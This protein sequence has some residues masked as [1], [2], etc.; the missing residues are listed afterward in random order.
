MAESLKKF[1]LP[2]D[3]DDNDNDDL[4]TEDDDDEDDDTIDDE[5]DENNLFVTRSIGIAE[6]VGNIRN[7]YCR[8]RYID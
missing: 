4:E 5:D 2:P 8:I 1:A 7:Q 3:D 6:A